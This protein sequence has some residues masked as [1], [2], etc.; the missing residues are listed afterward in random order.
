M[1]TAIHQ[2]VVFEDEICKHLSTHGWTFDGPLPYK[3]GHAYDAC[4]DRR[5]ALVPEDAI[6]WVKKTQPE[7]WAKFTAHHSNEADAQKEFARLLSAELNREHKQIKKDDPQLWGSLRLLRRGFKHINASFKMAQ[8]A[9]ANSLNPKLWD[10]FNANI[11]RV[12]RQ[13]HYSMHNEKCIDLVLFINGIPVATVEIKTETTQSIEEAVKQ[14]RHDRLPRDEASNTDEPLLTFGRR[15]LVH[16]ALSSD[17]VR[18]TTK[19]DGA[20]TRFLPFNRGIPDGHGGASAGNPADVVRGHA[21]AYFWHEVL[22]RETFL[23][24]VGKFISVELKESVNLKTGKKTLTP[25]LLFPRYHQLDA[26]ETLLDATLKEG[27]G[28][29]YLV[30]HSAGSGKSNTIGWSAHRLS[31]LFD[32]KN[33]KVFSSVI[34]ITDRRVLDQQLQDTIK[35]FESTPGVVMKIDEDSAQLAKALDGEAKIIVTTLQKF[36]FVLGKMGSMKDRTFAIIIDEAHS[37]QSGKSAIKLREALS[38]EGLK[39]EAAEI[40]KDDGE[41]GD[42][43]V[44][45]EEL[46]AKVIS[47]RKR[48][49]NISYY[50][51]TA[52]PK[53]KTLELFGRKAKDG[54]PK[55]FHVYSMRQAIEEGFIL[56]VLKGYVTYDMAF[57]LEQAGEDIE[58]KSGKARTKIFKY[59]SIHPT[60][61]G[62][63]IAIIVEHYRKHVMHLLN[64]QAKA[65]VVTDSRKAAVRY[66]KE[67]DKYMT[68]MGYHDFKAL[69]AYSGKITD[70]EYGIE[71]A[72]EGDVN[73]GTPKIK[74]DLIKEAFRTEE[75]RVLLVANKFQ[76]GFDEPLLCAMYVDKRLDDVMAVQTLSRLNRILSGKTKTFVLDF[77]N[78]AEDILA[79]F[80]PYYRTAALSATTDP[81]LPHQLREKLDNASVYLWSEVEAFAKLYFSARNDQ[82]FQAHLKQAFDRYQ[83]LGREEQELFRRDA[84]TYVTSYD[85]LSQL[86]DY[87][88]QELEKLHAFLQMLLPRLRGQ[89]ADPALIDGSVRLAGYKLVNKREHGLD[90]E[91]GEVKAIDPLS[92]G[93]GQAWDDPNEKLSEIIKKIHCLFTGKYSDAEVAGWFTAVAGNV[94]A[95][96]RIQMQAKANPTAGQFANGDYKLVLGEAIAKALASHHAMSEQTLQN[97]KVFEDV[98][99]ALLAEVYEKARSAPALSF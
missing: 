88:D 87:G 1:T 32:T 96:E 9:P 18:M 64:G 47:A 83:E 34:V 98:A 56:D 72:D 60:A 89:D 57:K 26:V 10:D 28:K 59:V 80:E 6:A 8:F 73:G 43:E 20:K 99:E 49:P 62:Q 44:S 50:A 55:P 29:A 69:V 33:Q 85:F 70:Q 53:A 76:V 79:A 94:A 16:L 21:T 54:L 97:P 75:Y 46:I 95:D 78:K 35:Q 63:K 4:Y 48:P 92:A 66:K 37:S 42:G 67:F 68:T 23:D 22:S 13:V 25:T 5:L 77:R 7:A 61:I 24:I 81:N 31:T 65:M 84:A 17:E 52:T 93:G 71:D 11:L 36:P 74:D 41:E 51:F 45:S 19:L 3:K 2:E 15:A 30:Q 14:Y 91:K 40:P 82:A 12:V 90:L 38:S 39:K 86:I 58:V 27:V